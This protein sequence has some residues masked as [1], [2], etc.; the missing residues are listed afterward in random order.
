[1]LDGTKKYSMEKFGKKCFLLGQD[2]DGINYFLEAATW[3]Y[4]WYWGGG[5]VRTYTNNRNPIASR[6][7]KSHG[8]FDELFFNGRRNGF[9]TFKEFLPANPFT[10]SEIWK[11]CE[12]MKSFYIAREYAEMV[13][14]GSA[15]YTTNPAAEIIK[16]EDVYK[17]INNIV[18]PAI[19]KSLYEILE[20]ASKNE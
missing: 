10:D 7:I 16:S 9:N 12:L 5:W 20:E 2:K 11:I 1:M 18:I 19:M 6:H 3:D 13:Y 14:T 17:R 8:H 4:E 15:H